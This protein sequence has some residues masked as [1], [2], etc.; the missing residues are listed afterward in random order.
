MRKK[1]GLGTTCFLIVVLALHDAIATIVQNY[2][3]KEKEG[4]GV[5]GLNLP[6]LQT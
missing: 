2:Y 3:S 5:D 4:G 6:S 1:E